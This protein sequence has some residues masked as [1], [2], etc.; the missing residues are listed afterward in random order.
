MPWRGLEPSVQPLSK[1]AHAYFVGQRMARTAA[2]K[3]D[4]EINRNI[5]WRPTL[6]FK[7]GGH[8]IVAVEVSPDMPYPMALKINSNSISHAELP[9]TVYAACPEDV[10]LTKQ[11][12]V[13]E[14]QS[15]G[16][17]LLTVDSVGSVTKRFGGA[18]LVQHIPEDDFRKEVKDLPQSIVRD[19][20][21]A[22]ELYNNKPTAGLAQVGEIVEAATNCAKKAVIKKGWTT[23]PTMGNSLANC[24]NC[25]LNLTQLDNAKAGIGRMRSFV[26]EYRNT[27]HHAPKSQKAAYERLSECRHG[28]L[29]GIKSLQSFTQQLKKSYGITIKI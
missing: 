21:E 4:L 7:G 2:I 10:F 22:F 25:M 1:A 18:P 26:S 17:G 8:T 16:F 11:K 6:W 29:E 15:H 27:A 5:S 14:L 23:E 3:I 20:I 9:I 24:L 13:K 12:E 28:F 19:L